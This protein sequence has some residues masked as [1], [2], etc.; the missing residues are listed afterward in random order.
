[1]GTG[2]I[3]DIKRFA[4]HDGP[5]I[6]TTVFLKGCPLSCW[7]CHNPE[8]RSPRPEILHRPRLC[9]RC[10][11]C[12]E[13]CPEAARALSDAGVTQEAVRCAICGAC[14]DAC[15]SGALET[16]GR[17]VGV[18]ELMTEIRKDT[19]F[20]DES[21]GGV[22]FSGGE[23]SAQPEFLREVLARCG[24]EDIHTVVD[25]CG[26]VE[27]DVLQSI[28][29]ETDL[30]LFDL[31]VFDPERH[32]ELTGVRNELILS[33]L[34]MLAEL[35]KKIQVR[36]PVIPNVTDAE[37][38]LDAICGFVRFL[39]NRPRITLLAHHA[40]AMEKYG[41]F[42]RQTPLPDDTPSVSRERLEEIASRLAGDGLEVEY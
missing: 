20:Y 12:V 25:T 19:P 34:T 15:P 6:R 41:R 29:E 23:P 22:T 14:A 18:D 36:V 21:G 17:R 9:V 28:A 31:K 24:D 5:G 40:S 3:F 27:P 26:F 7:W 37:D 39:K 33:N 11:S 8:S 42:D 38:N 10:G 2:I 1:V 16:I 35:D 4:I 32:A 30:F 13:T